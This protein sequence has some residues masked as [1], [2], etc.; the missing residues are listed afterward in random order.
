MD[1]AT[2]TSPQKMRR[3][4]YNSMVSTLSNEQLLKPI[5]S[6]RVL[7]PTSRHSQISALENVDDDYVSSGDDE[8]D[9]DREEESDSDD[10]DDMFDDEYDGYRPSSQSTVSVPHHPSDRWSSARSFENSVT[11]NNS[12]RPLRR[13]GYANHPPS[14]ISEEERTQTPRSV[15]SASTE[16]SSSSDDDD[17]NEEEQR[18]IPTCPPLFEDSNKSLLQQQQQQPGSYASSNNSSTTADRS[19]SHHH[20]TSAMH[21][22][23]TGGVGADSLFTMQSMQN[24]K[25][26]TDSFEDEPTSESETNG[27]DDDD[28]DD[29]NES[30]GSSSGGAFDDDDNHDDDQTSSANDYSSDDYDWASPNDRDFKNQQLE[31]RI[32]HRDEE[33]DPDHPPSR[34][35]PM[36][37]N[38]DDE[39]DEDECRYNDEEHSSAGGSSYGS[40]DGR[41]EDESTTEGEGYSQSELYMST[42]LST[43]NEKGESAY[44]D[45]SSG[46]ISRA[47]PTKRASG[48]RR[49]R[50]PNDVVVVPSRPAGSDHSLTLQD[51]QDDAQH[52][53]KTPQ[54]RHKA[55]ITTFSPKPA[56]TNIGLASPGANSTFSA[57][58]LNVNA[59]DAESS[60]SSHSST[61]DS[62]NGDGN[63][64]SG[65]SS[66]TGMSSQEE[67]EG[68]AVEEVP[69]W[70]SRRCFRVALASFLFFL[71]IDA[72]LLILF[73]V[74]RSGGGNDDGGDD[75]RWLRGGSSSNA[76]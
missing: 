43:I 8:N 64:S 65:S 16:G 71:L 9:S 13:E 54:S 62:S 31:D 10:D 4:S 61:T 51:L 45:M 11:A 28:D 73:I 41:G 48:R 37:R 46:Q 59:S 39:E 42:A 7:P 66:D 15:I 35:S 50:R 1:N 52:H 30:G 19:S 67:T 3:S 38:D 40:A 22:A 20:S 12:Q 70:K 21:P 53:H 55:R 57:F 44:L 2:A 69:W 29:D 74:N 26:S 63:G 60:V 72:V 49:G 34:A 47:T 18:F 32:D 36:N 27:N 5:T 68:D 58:T 23:S 14:A 6:I 75:R 17:D 24:V 76:Q 33:Y 56:G 25:Q